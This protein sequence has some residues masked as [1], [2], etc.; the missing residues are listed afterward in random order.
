MLN[1]GMD[2]HAADSPVAFRNALL[3]QEMAIPGVFEDPDAGLQDAKNDEDESEGSTDWKSKLKEDFDASRDRVSKDNAGDKADDNRR[4]KTKMTD[5]K[6][7]ASEEY[8]EVPDFLDIRFR[9]L[10]E[11]DQ[12]DSDGREDD[13][14]SGF[15]HRTMCATG[16]MTAY[17]GQCGYVCLCAP[18]GVGCL[19]V[20]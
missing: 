9:R 14:K 11:S 4:K 8:E 19:P 12:T 5:G 20:G 16:G 6:G 18:S 17:S 1:V 3:Q 7:G 2:V 13:S 10:Q 15:D